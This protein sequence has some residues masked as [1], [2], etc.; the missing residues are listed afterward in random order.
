[1][2]RIILIIALFLGLGLTAGAQ[3]YETGIGLRGGLANGI[4]LKHFT[5]SDQA[6]EGIL[7]TRWQGFMVTGLLEF[8][9]G[10]RHEGLSWF[11]GFGAHA[12]FFGGY[13]GH[14]WFD[15][16]KDYTVLGIDG[17][18]GLEYVFDE[19]PISVGLDWKPAFNLT[20]HSGFWGSDGAFSIRYVW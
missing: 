16:N 15:D 12:G 3:E 19:V 6:L 4:T 20:G 17:I 1:M 7:T 5:S 9:E 11:Y 14:P 10:L 2:H 8:Q 13:D 18:L